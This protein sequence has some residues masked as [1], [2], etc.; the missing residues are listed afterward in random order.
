MNALLDEWNRL[1]ESYDKL[2]DALLYLDPGLVPED[3]M[4]AWL[5][6]QLLAFEV[7][8]MATHLSEQAAIHALRIARKL[9]EQKEK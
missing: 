3:E 5:E 6:I 8:N 1:R 9:D 2:E 7:K 4:E